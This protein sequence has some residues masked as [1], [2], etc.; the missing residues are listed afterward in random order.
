[1]TSDHREEA[2]RQLEDGSIHVALVH[3][4]LA[5]ASAG[6]AVACELRGMR[7]DSLPPAVVATRLARED[8]GVAR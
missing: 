1:M 2:L 7:E 6:R 3:A 8:G 5:V 4:V